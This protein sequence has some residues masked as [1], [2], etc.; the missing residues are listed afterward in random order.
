[1]NIKNIYW[2]K[3]LC[4]RLWLGE[5]AF[6]EVEEHIKPLVG[7]RGKR[8]C[9]DC[10]KVILKYHKWQFGEDGRPQHRFCDLPESRDGKEAEAELSPDG[11][12]IL[13]DWAA[14]GG[15]LKKAIEQETEKL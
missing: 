2:W 12:A 9:A 13:G 4:H 8:I 15:D 1:M 10:H 11:Q 5:K 3:C 6:S 7:V 14:V